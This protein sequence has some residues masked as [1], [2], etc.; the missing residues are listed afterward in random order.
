MSEFYSRFY[1]VQCL[2]GPC[3]APEKYYQVLKTFGNEKLS[4]SQ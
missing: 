4:V 1:C 3:P 2:D